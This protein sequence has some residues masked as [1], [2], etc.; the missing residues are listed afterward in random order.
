VYRIPTA[1]SAWGIQIFWPAAGRAS[2]RSVC[3]QTSRS[4]SCPPSILRSYWKNPTTGVWRSQPKGRLGSRATGRRGKCQDILKN[5]G[6]SFVPGRLKKAL[7]PPPRS[8]F[9]RTVA[10]KRRW[11]TIVL[12]AVC[13]VIKGKFHRLGP[14]A[15]EIASNFDALRF[16]GA[17]GPT[18]P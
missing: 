17:T 4:Q 10:P 18:N 14:I 3:G 11:H 1:Y 2:S 12:F 8:N 16:I 7:M 6:F 15:P 9:R 13:A 5:M